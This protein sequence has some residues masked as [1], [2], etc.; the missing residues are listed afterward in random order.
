MG[1]CDK[2]STAAINLKVFRALWCLNLLSF[3]FALLQRA[4]SV[5]I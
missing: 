5:D 4:V 1:M 3:R 2:R